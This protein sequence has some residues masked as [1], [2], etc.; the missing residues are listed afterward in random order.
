VPG[1]LAEAVFLVM[2]D[3]SMNDLWVT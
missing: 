1:V 2:R 3:P